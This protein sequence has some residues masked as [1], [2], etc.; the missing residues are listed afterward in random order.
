VI[1]DDTTLE[2]VV[3]RAIKKSMSAVQSLGEGRHLGI[4]CGV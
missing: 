4:D 1:N 3:G 2:F